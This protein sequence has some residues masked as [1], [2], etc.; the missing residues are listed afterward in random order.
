MKYRCVRLLEEVGFMLAEAKKKKKK[1]MRELYYMYISCS[2]DACLAQ[3]C[4]RLL[5]E[6]VTH[7]GL[8]KHRFWVEA[9]G[10]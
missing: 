8:E 7:T 1:V 4:S 10:V 2:Q 9:V 5:K 3:D 6:A